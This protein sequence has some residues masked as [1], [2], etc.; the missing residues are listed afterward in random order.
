MP[1]PV[2]I[3]GVGCVTPLGVGAD[4]MHAGW[5]AGTCALDDGFGRCR[6]FVPEDSLT[7]S[8]IRRYDRHVQLALVAAD[9]ALEQA[10]WMGSLPYPSHRI[11]CVMA[12]A[13]AGQRTV[14]REL[15]AFRAHGARGVAPLRLL[16]AL[17]NA[18]AVSVA[19]RFGLQGETF[20]LLGACAGGTQAIGAGLRMI[21]AGAADAVV[22]GGT[23]AELAELTRAT[24]AAL[25][26]T[27]PTGRCLPFD[28]RRDGMVAAEGAGVLVLES[29]DRVCERGAA[30]VA[31][32]LG[33]GAGNDA[34]HLTMPQLDGQ[35]RVMRGALA[36]AN[37]APREVAYANAHG[38]GT[39]LNDA[40]ETAAL[41]ATFNGH[42]H[43]LR[44]SSIKSA[45]G[46]LQ[47]G[48]GAVEAIATALCLRERVAGPTLGLDEPDDELDLD[49]VAHIAQPLGGASDQ[50]PLM[51]MSSSFGLGGHS[52]CVVLRA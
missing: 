37:A 29:A 27:S 30:P 41:K 50:A 2:A 35:I 23:E 46:H 39:R 47:G 34:H 24:Y 49:Y 32:L 31:E 22:V 20:G 6:D 43:D 15:D 38:T 51:G 33:Y 52:A 40:T 18:A 5:L 48:A 12:T 28:R 21:R 8:E 17:P 7:R 19:M 14:E 3:T 4:R 13:M 42:A 10:G 16:L 26:A 36:D 9:E 44:V 11:G 25:G 1:E 45:I